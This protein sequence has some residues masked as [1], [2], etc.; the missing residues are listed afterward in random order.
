MSSENSVE[1]NQLA[2]SQRAEDGKPRILE[3]KPSQ[4]TGNLS[5]RPPRDS[6]PT[7][8][9]TQSKSSIP[10]PRN[11]KNGGTVSNRTKVNSSISS[12]QQ[13]AASKRIAWARGN[14]STSLSTT[15]STRPTSALSNRSYY[16]TPSTISRTSLNSDLGSMHSLKLASQLGT[17]SSSK[18][19]DHAGRNNSASIPQAHQPTT[20]AKSFMKPTSSSVAKTRLQMTKSCE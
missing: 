5:S 20:A 1:S 8:S 4:P 14:G 11:E 10:V 15:A 17:L 3:R 6:A 19:L 13:S 9:F 16:R 12:R 7:K 18:S 2:T